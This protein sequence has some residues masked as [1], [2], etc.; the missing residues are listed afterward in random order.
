MQNFFKSSW[1]Q[2]DLLFQIT[3]VN[4][5]VVKLVFG[6]LPKTGHCQCIFSPLENAS[7]PYSMTQKRDS[8]NHYTDNM[9]FD[10]K[11]SCQGTQYI[12]NMHST[13]CGLLWQNTILLF[14]F[15]DSLSSLKF[16]QSFMFYEHIIQMYTYFSMCL[17]ILCYILLHYIMLH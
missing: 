3:H 4:T 7:T 2:K 12:D 17:Y 11:V 15:N 10:V 6:K 13:L 8:W 5:I 14:F 16:Y 1:T 9:E